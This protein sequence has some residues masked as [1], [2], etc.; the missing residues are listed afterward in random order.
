VFSIQNTFKLRNADDAVV[1]GKVSKKLKYKRKAETLKQAIG[2]VVTDLRV[3]RN[4]S[5]A[6]V[7]VRSGYGRPWISQ[8]ENGKVN[9]RL[10]LIIAF[11]DTFKLSLA[12]FFARAERKHF[13]AKPALRPVS[14]RKK[15]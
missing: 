12:Q 9:P 4:W 3:E 5:Q 1:A 11:A 8:L 6:E 7:A 14:P 10:E 2:A 13:K 15:S